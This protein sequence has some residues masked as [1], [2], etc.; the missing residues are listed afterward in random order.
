M[1]RGNLGVLKLL[2]SE[3]FYKVYLYLIYIVQ[4]STSG[5]CNINKNELGMDGNIFLCVV[6]RPLFTVCVRKSAGRFS[7]PQ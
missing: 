4:F 1:F 5:N 6:I 7:L 2:L 3:A